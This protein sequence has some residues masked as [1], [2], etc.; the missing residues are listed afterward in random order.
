MCILSGL[1]WYQ[2][3]TDITAINRVNGPASSTPTPGIHADEMRNQLGNFTK[4]KPRYLLLLPFS[5]QLLDDR[6]EFATH[7]TCM[8]DH[9]LKREECENI[10]NGHCMCVV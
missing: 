7:L 5:I 8:E 3:L 4:T 6:V 9:K 2:F 1:K 10:D